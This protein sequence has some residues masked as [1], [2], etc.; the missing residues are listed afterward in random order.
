MPLNFEIAKRFASEAI[1]REMARSRK[2]SK[3]IRFRTTKDA[4][5]HIYYLKRAGKIPQYRYMNV[6]K[7]RAQRAR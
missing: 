5:R 4:F 3:K 7:C 6:Y 2:C 1:N